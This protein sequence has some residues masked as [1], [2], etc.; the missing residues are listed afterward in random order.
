MSLKYA[1][2]SE[3]GRPRCARRREGR[4]NRPRCGQDGATLRPT[5][6]TRNPKPKTRNPE[7][8]TQNPNPPETRDPELGTENLKPEARNPKPET[9]DPTRRRR[10]STMAMPRAGSTA[11]LRSRCS[12]LPSLPPSLPPSLT[13]SFNQS[14]LTPALPPSLSHSLPR[15]TLFLKPVKIVRR[16]GGLGGTW[17]CGG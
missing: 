1:P 6:E 14:K 2:S 10:G 7:P 16:L 4:R 17:L 5:P 13:H 12:L 3:Q 15:A 8:G 9:R 11:L